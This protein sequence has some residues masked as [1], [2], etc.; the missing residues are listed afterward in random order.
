MT[1]ALLIGTIGVLALG[2]VIAW[3]FGSFLDA[4]GCTRLPETLRNVRVLLLAPDDLRAPLLL[5]LDARHLSISAPVRSEL[6]DGLQFSILLALTGSD[7]ENLRL[8][9]AARRLSPGSAAVA[10]CRDPLF[11][12]LYKSVGADRILPA[13]C[14][15]EEVLAA[16][17]G[18][19]PDDSF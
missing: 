18:L 12:H 13:D 9:S 2:F 1:A 17:K 10:R 14:T 3:R 15:P 11:L 4:G 6:P 16:M 7:F 8:C 5:Q 19:L